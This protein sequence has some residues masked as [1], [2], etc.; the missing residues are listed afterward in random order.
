MLRERKVVVLP[1]VTLEV[2]GKLVPIHSKKLDW[3]PIRNLVIVYVFENMLEPVVALTA[4]TDPVPEAVTGD[5]GESY[6]RDTVVVT[7]MPVKVCV[8]VMLHEYV[9]TKRLKLTASLSV[10]LVPV[11]ITV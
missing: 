10:P 6:E 4:A 8:L 2:R 1:T 5:D 9:V 11:T 3:E 7:L